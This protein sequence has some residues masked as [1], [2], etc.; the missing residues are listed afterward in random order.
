MRAT[1]RPLVNANVARI[2]ASGIRKYRGRLE[3]I[4]CE[5]IALAAGAP[6]QHRGNKR[7]PRL[8]TQKHLRA[9]QIALEIGIGTAAF[10]PDVVRQNRE[11]ELIGQ[12]FAEGQIKCADGREM[13]GIEFLKIGQGD[14][15]ARLPRL[16]S[17]IAIFLRFVA[18]RASGAS[19]VPSLAFGTPLTI[20]R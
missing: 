17:T 10:V 19:T 13:I 9:T 2:S 16:P 11:V 8:R 15:S 3:E 6:R 14:A 5:Q 12:K 1:R 7:R 4:G 18:E 20:A